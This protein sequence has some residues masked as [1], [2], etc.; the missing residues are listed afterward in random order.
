MELVHKYRPDKVADVVGQP[1]AVKLIGKYLHTKTLPHAVLLYGPSGT[2]KTTLARIAATSVTVHDINLVETNCAIIEPMKVVRGIE[3]RARGRPMFGGKN[4][5]VLDEFQ[6]LSRAPRTQEAFLK[7]LEDEEYIRHSYFFICTTE[8]SKI[9][10]TVRNRCT[11]V[12]CHS[13]ADSAV[14]LLVK[15]VAKLEKLNASTAAVAKVV[16]LAQGSPRRALVAIDKLVGVDPDEH[17]TILGERLGEAVDAIE[18]P[19]TLLKSNSYKDAMGVVKSLMEQEE[20]VEGLRKITLAYVNK[21]LASRKDPRALA[22]L[23]AFRDAWYD[24]LFSGLIDAVSEL[25]PK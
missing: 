1:E 2:G 19:R 16:Q 15:R 18:L 14:E 24:C 17:L 3:E 11:E 4:A 8:P 23:R 22:I 7:M 13:V 6:A 20:D 10:A 25:C 5:F 9:L 12:K 21:I